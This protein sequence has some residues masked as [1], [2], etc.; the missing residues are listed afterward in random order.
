MQIKWRDLHGGIVK[1]ERWER[2][3]DAK[4][5]EMMRRAEPQWFDYNK[6]RLSQGIEYVSDKFFL[7]ENQ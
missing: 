6:L 1:N 4:A 5:L 2:I 3:S 7:R